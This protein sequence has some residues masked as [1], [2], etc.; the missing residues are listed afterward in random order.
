MAAKDAIS[1][2]FLNSIFT[3]ENNYLTQVFPVEFKYNTDLIL[4]FIHL[5][6]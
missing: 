6:I 2:V 5:K 1:M 3:V 4:I